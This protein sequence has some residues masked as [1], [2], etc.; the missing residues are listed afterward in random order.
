MNFVVACLARVF[1]YSRIVQCAHSSD[2]RFVCFVFVK[3]GKVDE[4][5]LPK[6]RKSTATDITLTT[7][8]RTSESRDWLKG[9]RSKAKL[10]PRSGPEGGGILPGNVTSMKQ[11]TQPGVEASPVATSMTAMASAPAITPSPKATARRKKGSQACGDNERVRALTPG[12]RADCFFGFCLRIPEKLC[13]VH[14]KEQH[15]FC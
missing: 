12:H 2:L 4:K 5:R 6:V 13:E 11:G 14:K 7:K 1:L 10:A 8:G 3:G 9:N 15:S